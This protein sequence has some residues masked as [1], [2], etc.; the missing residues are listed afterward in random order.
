[1]ASRRRTSAPAPGLAPGAWWLRDRS[2]TCCLL[3]RGRMTTIAKGRSTH[4][5]GRLRGG[6]GRHDTAARDVL[7]YMDTSSASA[8]ERECSSRRNGTLARLATI[9]PMAHSRSAVAE[10]RFGGL[11]G[12]LTLLVT[13]GP[14]GALVSDEARTECGPLDGRVAAVLDLDLDQLRDEFGRLLDEPTLTG[15]VLIAGSEHGTFSARL[16]LDHGRG[17]VA[18]S[19]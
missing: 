16:R 5:P 7:P 11:E 14:S 4:R 10:M 2:P 18:I 8:G 6:R 19:L 1:R 13:P 3:R 17:T 9:W 12:A 15:D